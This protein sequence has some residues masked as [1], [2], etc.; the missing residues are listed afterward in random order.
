[1][2]TEQ[3]TSQLLSIFPFDERHVKYHVCCV[4]VD[5]TGVVA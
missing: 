2:V 4:A 1:M 5:R 3:R